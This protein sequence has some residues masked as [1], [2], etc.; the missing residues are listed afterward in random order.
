MEIPQSNPLFYAYKA[1]LLSGHPKIRELTL[2]FNIFK[3]PS[4]SLARKGPFNFY[5]ILIQV[6]TYDL[7]KVCCKIFFLLFF[8]N[9]FIEVI[10][11]GTF[12]YGKTRKFFIQTSFDQS[13]SWVNFDDLAP[14]WA[15]YRNSKI[16][17]KVRQSRNV[18]FKPTI[19]P[20]KRT[21]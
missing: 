15:D 10:L 16:L 18:F 2:H 13:M 12:F 8:K 19:L 21:N 20:K 5:I 6:H 17:F 1:P 7:S 14:V 9:V 11:L 4:I 3:F